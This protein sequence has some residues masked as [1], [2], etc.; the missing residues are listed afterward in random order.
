MQNDR[1]LYALTLSAIAAGVTGV[2]VPLYLV[3][4]G[5][6]AAVLGLAAALSS[7]VGAPAAILAGRYADRS[8]TPRDIVL[9]GLTLAALAAVLFP[10]FGT[11]PGV[12]ALNA[13]LAIALA[14]VGPVVTMFVV[15]GVPDAAW[16]ARIARLNT[17][18]GFGGIGGL[19][20]GTVWTGLLTPVTSTGTAYRSL[21]VVAALIAVAAI[22]IAAR[23][24][25]SRP[26]DGRD[27]IG[28]H[29]RRDAT[30]LPG[31]ARA[32]WL[33]RGFGRRGLG[34]LLRSFPG[35]LHRYFA[36]G[37]LFFLGFGAFWAPLPLYLTERGFDASTIFA[38]Y[39]LNNATSTL[40][41]TA[42]G[43]LS[44]THDTHR[45]QGGALGVRGIAFMGV[46]IL[47][48]AGVGPGP[49]LTS[50]PVVATLLAVIGLTWAVIAVTGTAIVSRRAP[51][52]TRGAIL[53]GY[54]ALS[55]LGGRAG[56]LLGGWVASQSFG[57]AFAMAGTLV[58]AGGLIVYR[59]AAPS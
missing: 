28:L 40:S 11:V 8:E 45:L 2:L 48:V 6:G 36:A 39:V 10:V 49:S 27:P 29:L 12:V 26:E 4:L 13:V 35:S 18:Q 58:I 23:S 56:S 9:A 19:V 22:L 21:F 47:A 43:R 53:G 38:L 3:R 15:S 50:L 44:L 51:G 14:A 46:G 55:A 16:D 30:F 52:G 33:A 17:Y 31:T 37:A 25:P 32:Y 20:L 5:A 1:W 59:M 41:F 24:L 34:Q 7:I 57:L 42:V 54:T